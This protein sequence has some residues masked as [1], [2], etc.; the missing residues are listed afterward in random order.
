[1]DFGGWNIRRKGNST[2]AAASTIVPM[3]RQHI[4]NYTVKVLNEIVYQ[5][6]NASGS[7]QYWNA[8]SDVSLQCQVESLTVVYV[9]WFHVLH[10][11]ILQTLSGNRLLNGTSLTIKHCNYEDTGQYVCVLSTDTEMFSVATNVTIQDKPVLSQ[12]IVTSMDGLIKLSLLFYSL[13]QPQYVLWLKNNELVTDGFKSSLTK[14][15]IYCSCTIARKWTND[16]ALNDSSSDQG[17]EEIEMLDRELQDRQNTLNQIA[18][19][20]DNE[21]IQDETISFR[22]YENVFPVNSYEDLDQSRFDIH[23]YETFDAE[24]M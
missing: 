7:N 13:P 6:A 15:N 10:G 14:R 4:G 18:L 8:T 17:Y 24:R 20:E 23:K 3:T 16:A 11:N 21:G 1:M 9:E 12:K 22:S 19:Q 2:F 5:V